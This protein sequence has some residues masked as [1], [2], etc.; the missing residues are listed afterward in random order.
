MLR[1]CG[2]ARAF[3]VFALVVAVP[4]C[5]FGAGANAYVRHDLVS[6]TPGA[7]DVTDPNL[8]NPWGVSFSAAG[9][10]WISNTGKGNSTV[11]NGS[12]TITPLV[13]T[14]P[15]A[16]S[17]TKL[18]TPTGQVNNNTTA[19]ILANGN[20]ASFIFSSEDGVITAWN[21]GTAA[22]IM[23]DN[24]KS[25]AV[26]YG[27]A[28]GTSSIGPTLYA[29]NYTTGNIDVFDGKF[30][31]ATLPGNFTDPALPAGYAP[32]NIW[33]LNGKLYVAYAKQGSLRG[34]GGEGVGAVAIFD[35][36]GNLVKHM[37]S[38][39]PL[40]APWGM[41]IAPSTFGAFAGALLVGNFGDGKINAFDA[42]TGAAL[43]ALQDTDGNPYVFP[44]LWALIFGN[45]GNGGDR[46]ILYITAGVGGLQHGLF[47]SLAPPAAIVS[48]VNGAS[49]AS[50]PVAPGEVVVLTGIGL[51][52]SPMASAS[53]PAA[54][55]IRP[56]LAGMSVT[57]NGNPAP[58]LYCSASQ[59][60]VI[61]PYAL[62]GFSSAT[63]NVTFKGQTSTLQVPVV[64]AAPGVFTSNFSGSGQIVALNSDG[65][66]NSSTNP[67]SGGTV[68]TFFATGEG[69]TYPPG[70]DG[71]VND[72]IIRTPQLPPGVTIGGQQARLLYAGSA[73][74]QVQGVMQL[75]VLV[76]AGM[77]GSVPVVVSVGS[78][79][80]Q[81]NA[82]LAVKP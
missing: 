53:I 2:F 69:P 12:G 70:E 67:A 5:V 1:G 63:I 43:G 18:G 64:L 47:T 60:S 57:F 49:G 72:R 28:I 42:T 19:F 58:I 29:P 30:S 55:T 15:A 75:Q 80:S 46:N 24:S 35:F 41:A 40:N 39:S 22:A 25:N 9:P 33:P 68:V 73:A 13:V 31:P 54:G 52:P 76:P 59:T 71:V 20:K 37:L 3:A 38:G 32:F 7:A 10:F 21:T 27:L 45:G 36:D 74:G 81:T 4:A 23:V 8:V 50:G 77:T 14:V 44:G 61:V 56:D 17:S 78:G 34:A 82:T 79:T 66:L 51:G 48:V 26:Y 6:D 11:Y 62:A 16:G 65:S